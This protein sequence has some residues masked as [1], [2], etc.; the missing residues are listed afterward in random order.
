MTFKFSLDALAPAAQAARA[1]QITASAKLTAEALS[2]LDP[3]VPALL[4]QVNY[5]LLVTSLQRSGISDTG[6]ACGLAH[7]YFLSGD[8]MATSRFSTRWQQILM[9]KE[10]SED[11][12]LSSL[13]RLL[14]QAE[15]KGD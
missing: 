15:K 11:A 10:M 8:T 3:P 9:S 14:S 1:D 4:L 7:R 12:R 6:A 2:A 5:R 13:D